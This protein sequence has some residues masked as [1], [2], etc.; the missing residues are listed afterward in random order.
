ML[1]EEEIKITVWPSIIPD[2]CNITLSAPVFP[3][4]TFNFA[5]KESAKG[6]PVLEAL[7]R[8]PWLKEV[9]ATHDTLVIKKKGTENW[10]ELGIK[11]GEIIRANLN[12]D[13]LLFPDGFSPPISQPQETEEV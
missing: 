9:L 1:T 2:V 4:Q 3:D 13:F 10:Q 12:Q 11:I 5:D 8:E 6:S 7:F